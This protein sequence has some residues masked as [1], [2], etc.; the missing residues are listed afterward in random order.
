MVRTM[1]LLLFLAA[2][3]CAVRGAQLA[4]WPRYRA[5][6]DDAER[7]YAQMLRELFRPMSLAHQVA[8]AQ[9][10]GSLALG[11]VVGIVTGNPVFA[12]GSA[13]CGFVLPRFVFDR[14]RRQRLAAI[15]LQLPAALRV[16]ADAAKAGLALPQ[17]I[18]LVAA[19][20]QKPIAD[21]FGLVVHAMEFGESVE[22]ALTRVGSRLNLPNFDLMTTALVVNRDRGGDIAVLLV[23]LADAIRSISEVEQRIETETAAVRLS[24]KIMVGTI[25][26]FALALFTIDPAGVTLLFTT[27]PG[28]VVLVLVAILATAGYRM[29]L[30]LANPEV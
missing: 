5:R 24:A 28:A 8:M 10:V 13:A 20:G 15:N 18:R 16:M 25:P 21:E 12:L 3:A 7:G 22:D 11:A 27:L 30:R 6:I 23:R 29:I 14:L 26:L 19:Q 1:A 17:M 4:L 9:Y 2:A